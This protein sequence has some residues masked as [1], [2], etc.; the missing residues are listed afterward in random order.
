MVDQSAVGRSF[1]PVTAHV[2]P[3]RLRYFFN[4]LGERNPI[5]RD[6]AVAR[7]NGYSAVPA[8]PTYLF[9]LEM[10]DS[11]NPFEFLTELKIDLARVLHGEQSFLYRAPVVV[12]DTLTFSSRVASVADK[13]GGAMTLIVVETAVTNQD[14]IH[15]ADISRT[16]VVRN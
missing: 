3:G 11:D 15:V 13:K 5:Y 6:A 16:I 10:M 12:G 14:G 9:C 4:T 8:P 7:T 1:T 2:E